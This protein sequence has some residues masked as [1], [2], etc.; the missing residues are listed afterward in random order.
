MSPEPARFRRHLQQPLMNRSQLAVVREFRLI[1]DPV[2]SAANLAPA[3]QA[4]AGALSGKQ[5][6]LFR[7]DP[8]T[9]ELNTSR[10][11]PSLASIPWRDRPRPRAAAQHPKEEKTC[12]MAERSRRIERD[13]AGE[14]SVACGIVIGHRSGASRR[15]KRHSMTTM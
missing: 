13:Q 2:R 8:G 12:E 14:R 3:R 11:L 10:M 4:V 7:Q 9:A 6:C 15:H 1:G 5:L